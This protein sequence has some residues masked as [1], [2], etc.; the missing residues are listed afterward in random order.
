MYDQR[1]VWKR[2]GLPHKYINFQ[3]MI[4]LVSKVKA[5]VKYLVAVGTL[6]SK[7]S[8]SIFLGN[9]GPGGRLRGGRG[10]HRVWKRKTKEGLCYQEGEW[11]GG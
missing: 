2:K 7:V 8:G 9:I 11:G 3:I 4:G 5:I 1:S 10:G 6:F